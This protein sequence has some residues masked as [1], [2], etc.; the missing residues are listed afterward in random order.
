[1]FWEEGTWKVWA[2]QKFSQHLNDLTFMVFLRRD[3]KRKRERRRDKRERIER[4]IERKEG[5]RLRQKE[6]K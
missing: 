4:V 6:R 5:Y 3:S 1:M 2:G